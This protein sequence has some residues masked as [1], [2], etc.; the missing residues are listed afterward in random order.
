MYFNDLSIF[1]YILSLV[2]LCR[3]FDIV[4]NVALLCVILFGL[5]Y[6]LCKRNYLLKVLVKGPLYLILTNINFYNMYYQLFIIMHY[7]LMIFEVGEVRKCNVTNP[8]T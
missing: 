1:E 4:K 7:Y 6:C 3:Q 5:K 2:L 8:D